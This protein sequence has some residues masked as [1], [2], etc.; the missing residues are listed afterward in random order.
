MQPLTL[1]YLYRNTKHKLWFVWRSYYNTVECNRLA[2]KYTPT[3]KWI[4]GSVK[5]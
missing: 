1:R 4:M 2:T 3:I 5:E